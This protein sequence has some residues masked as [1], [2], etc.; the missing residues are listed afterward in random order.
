ML[1]LP[2]R[3]APFLADG[4]PLIYIDDVKRQLQAEID[5]TF[6]VKRQLKAEID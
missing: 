5:S 6:D 3:G 1:P 2:A 4:K